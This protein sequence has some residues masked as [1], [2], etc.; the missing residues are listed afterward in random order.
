MAA[1]HERPRWRLAVICQNERLWSLFAWNRVFRDNAIPSVYELVGF[2]SCREKFAKL[3]K[4]EVRGWY[5]RTFGLTTFVGLGMFHL[6]FR[7]VT[8]F[9]QIAGQYHTSF[10]GLCRAKQVRHH[11]AA[12]PNDPAFINWLITERIDVLV[13]MVGHIL[14]AKVLQAPAKCIINKHASVLPANKGIFPYFWACLKGEPQ[15]VSVHIV[16]ERIDDGPLVYQR[17]VSDADSLRSMISFYFH[18]YKDYPQQLMQALTNVAAGKY[19]TPS[20]DVKGSYHG[21]PTKE[22]VTAFRRHGGKILL[23]K[24]FFLPF[25]TR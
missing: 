6:V 23:F 16:S 7:L 12:S 4:R 13:I 9:K 1:N 22:D 15:G 21:L 19:I 11:H 24:D 25:N 3:K 8:A 14:R 5:R 2:W 10:M 17:V 20:V 18:T